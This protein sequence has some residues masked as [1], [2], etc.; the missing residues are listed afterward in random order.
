MKK[1]KKTIVIICVIII[2]M[3]FFRENINPINEII[4][5]I[6]NQER[7]LA[8]DESANF[9]DNNSKIK[10]IQCGENYTVLTL[11]SP[12]L[13]AVTELNFDHH[14][15]VKLDGEWDFYPNQL[16]DPTSEQ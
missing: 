7:R 8:Y 10:D 5:G 15:N 1:Y 2:F 14:Q 11:I 4:V 3:Y 12:Q 16:I 13:Y 9:E 6:S